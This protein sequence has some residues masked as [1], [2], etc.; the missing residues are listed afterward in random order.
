MSETL[1]KGKPHRRR[2]AWRLGE[3]IEIIPETPRTKSPI[4]GRAALDFLCGPTPLVEAV[5]TAL[6]DVGHD[7]SRVKTERLGHTGG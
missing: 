3:V 1:T 7:P 6:V 4:L 5:A 2:I